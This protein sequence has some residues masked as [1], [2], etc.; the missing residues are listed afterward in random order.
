MAQKHC[1]KRFPLKKSSSWE[2]GNFW[3]SITNFRH[4]KAL[5]QGRLCNKGVFFLSLFSCN[6]LTNW[7][8]TF[9]DLLFYANVGFHQVRILVFDIDQRWPV[10]SK[11]SSPY[12]FWNFDVKWS[13]KTSILLVQLLDDLRNFFIMTLLNHSICLIEDQRLYSRHRW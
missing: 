8:K 6:F 12:F 2:R 3:P 1:E 5:K 13:L 9:A 10:P 11:V 7:V 4:L